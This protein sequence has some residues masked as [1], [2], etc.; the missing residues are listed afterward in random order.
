MSS[1]NQIGSYGVVASFDGGL[2]YAVVGVSTV[3]LTLGTNGASFQRT[4]QRVDTRNS[5]GELVNVMFYDFGKTVSIRCYP[6]GSTLAN[7]STENVKDIKPGT[8]IQLYTASAATQED[9]VLA[10]NG[11]AATSGGTAYFVTSI[12]KTME[13]GNKVAWDMT[14]E[15][16]DAMTVAAIS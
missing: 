15:A 5:D 16:P 14:L 11:V 13:Q 2:T 3:A 7:A 1:P 8:I 4:A 9:T 10:A 6:R 12:T